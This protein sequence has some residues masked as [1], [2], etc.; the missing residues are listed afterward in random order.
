MKKT[1]IRPAIKVR[2]TINENILT[3]NSI[4]VNDDTTID[5]SDEILAGESIF[6]PIW[7]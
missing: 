5:N 4:P 3:V 1:Y 7:D 6:D 2:K